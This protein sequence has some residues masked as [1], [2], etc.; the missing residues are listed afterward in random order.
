MKVAPADIWFFDD[1]LINV[2]AAIQAGMVAHHVDREVGVIPT[3]KR[4]GFLQ[5]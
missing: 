4:L 3:L 2:E 1:T 5:G